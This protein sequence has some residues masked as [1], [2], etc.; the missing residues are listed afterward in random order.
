MM[1]GGMGMMAGGAMMGGM[2]SGYGG[3]GA[4]MVTTSAQRALMQWRAPA[5]LLDC[6]STCIC[7]S[8]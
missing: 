6:L 5:V 7:I 1:G 8:K 3:E 4:Y 2:R